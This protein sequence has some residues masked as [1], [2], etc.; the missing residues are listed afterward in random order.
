MPADLSHARYISLATF[1][2]G[3]AEVRTPVWFAASDDGHL[4]VFTAGDAGKVKRLRHTAR[5]R[6]APSGVRG[7][8]R[9][10][11]REGTAWL[12]TEPSAVAAAHAAL[13]AKY[14]WQMLAADLLA[15]LTGR[16]GRRAWV[17]IALG[18]RPR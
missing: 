4:H 1:R 10:A 12:V 15:R 13:R 6:V 9:G 8:V 17:E 2:R 5:V 11:W 7:E 3:G 14:G 16:L 18:P